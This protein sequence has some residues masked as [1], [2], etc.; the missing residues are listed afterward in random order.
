ME[1]VKFQECVYYFH[2]FSL[3]RFYIANKAIKTIFYIVILYL[4][5]SFLSRLL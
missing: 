5:Y 4:V 3:Y 2:I 1:K